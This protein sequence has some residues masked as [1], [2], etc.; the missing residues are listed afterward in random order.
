MLILWGFAVVIKII[1]VSSL[2]QELHLLLYFPCK[3]TQV[4]CPF[5]FSF[6]QNGHS[7]YFPKNG[8]NI[9]PTCSDFQFDVLHIKSVTCKA[10]WFRHHSMP[11][12][13]PKFCTNGWKLRGNW[14][15][16]LW[17]ALSTQFSLHFPV[18][19]EHRGLTVICIHHVLLY[20]NI[21]GGCPKKLIP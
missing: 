1:H 12:P 2:R 13:V 10:A 21:K 17:L 20:L 6:S 8:K 4:Y 19:P 14:N 5:P 15:R 18:N 9:A 3:S 7:F 16:A 11:M